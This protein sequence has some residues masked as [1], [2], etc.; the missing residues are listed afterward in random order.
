[1]EVQKVMFQI[2]E[3]TAHDIVDYL[4]KL[5]EL[6]GITYKSYPYLYELDMEDEKDYVVQYALSNNSILIAAHA[7]DEIVGMAVGLPLRASKPWIQKAFA[8]FRGN[9]GAVFYIGDIVLSSEDAQMKRQ[10]LK[11]LEHSVVKT[12]DYS[13]LA[14]CEVYREECHAENEA[15]DRF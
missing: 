9:L 7:H 13:Q 4:P 6:R 11:A 1:M 10:L 5:I 8:N 2:A 12:R 3:I 14:I 15:T